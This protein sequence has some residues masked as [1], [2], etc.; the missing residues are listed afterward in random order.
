MKNKINILIACEESQTVCKAFRERGFN[1]FSCDIQTCS[2]GHAEWHFLGDCLEVIKNKGG[3]LENGQEHFINGDWNLIIAHPPCTYLSCVAAPHLY[4]NG[5]LN[6][7]RYKKGIEAA[8]FFMQLYNLD[9]PHL[10]IE[11]PKQ[12]KI[13]NLP[14]YTQEIQPYY[15]GDHFS[16]RTRLWLKNLPPLLPTAICEKHITTDNAAWF[17][18]GGIKRQKNRSKTFQGIAQAMAEQWGNF[19]LDRY[20]TAMAK[21]Y[22]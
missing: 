8:N 3:K 7:E 5:V 19:V 4:K 21:I 17:Q 11:N 14:P 6:E 20:V 10:A 2:G 1:A 9:V 18:L 15:F 16:K 22:I 12:F 13:F